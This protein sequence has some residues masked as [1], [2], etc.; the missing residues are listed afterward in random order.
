M[1]RWA[2]AQPLPPRLDELLERAGA[3]RADWVERNGSDVLVFLPPH[4]VLSTGRLPLAGIQASYRLLLEANA[5]AVLLNGERLLNLSAADLAAWQPG[6]PLPRACPVNPPAPLEAALTLALLAADPGLEAS[7]HN[8]DARAERG[9]APADD[10]YA[11][12]CAATTPLAWWTTGTSSWSAARRKRIW[13]CCACNCWRWNRSANASF[14]PAGRPT[15]TLRWQRRSAS[16]PA[17]SCSV[18]AR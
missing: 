2:S 16:R 10:D 5:T 3:L 4:L 6:D 15:A 1:F 18:T 14:W 11:A 12:G 13:S 9:G 7:Y 17:T 8:L